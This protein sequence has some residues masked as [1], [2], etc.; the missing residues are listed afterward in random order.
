MNYHHSY[1]AGNFA[2]VLKHVVL[3]MLLER[4]AQK[5]T[6]FCV[7]D[8]HAGAGGYLL[9]SAEALKKREY[10]QG[11]APLF[12]A[13]VTTM[14]DAVS[15]YLNIVRHYNPDNQLLCYPGSPTIAAHLLREHDQLILCELHP[16][17]KDVL[18]GNVKGLHP[19]IAL[20]HL[21]GYLGMKA[22]LPPNQA[23]GLVLIDPPF[24]VTD[25]FLRILSALKLALMHWRAGQYVIWYPIKNDKAV[26]QFETSLRTIT[27]SLLFIHLR[28]NH[29]VEPGKLAACGLAL[30]NPPWQ[31]DETLRNSVL[32]YL[33]RQ[34]DATIALAN[35]GATRSG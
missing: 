6:P 26:K 17:E 1:H 4:L 25:E 34:L 24:E 16:D 13:D 30:I 35:Y 3:G 18:R 27:Q 8:T 14:P 7:L 19:N 2:D 5:P 28:I 22:F 21:D 10:E 32:P 12:N 33:A 11:I 23:R 9:N 29:P 31:L 15:R 20:H